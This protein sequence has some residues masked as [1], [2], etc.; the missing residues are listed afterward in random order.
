M[1]QEFAELCNMQKL[2][3]PAGA[4]S[5]L[6]GKD[7]ARSVPIRKEFAVEDAGMGPKGEN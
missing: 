1:L 2:R 5:S 7:T 3:V 4:V 6:F